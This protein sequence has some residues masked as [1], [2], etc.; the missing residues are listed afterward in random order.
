MLE[1][2]DPKGIG[3]HQEI[4]VVLSKSVSQGLKKKKSITKKVLG[5]FLCFCRVLQLNTGCCLT[6]EE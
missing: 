6:D 1:K 5:A 2:E 4:N 3:D